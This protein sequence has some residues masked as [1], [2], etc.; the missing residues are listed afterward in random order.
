MA[1]CLAN[2]EKP[3]IR[4]GASPFRSLLQLGEVLPGPRSG[5]TADQVAKREDQWVGNRVDTAGAIFATGDQAA[6]KKQLKVLGHIGLIGIE[7]SDQFGD[8][9]LRTRK[10]LQNAQPEGFPKI[11]KAP[12]DQLQH[13]IREGDFTHGFIISLH[14]HI[15]SWHM[16]MRSPP[17]E[18]GSCSAK[19]RRR[20]EK[21]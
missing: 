2:A 8:G 11:A 16:F 12:G 1:F 14:A 3:A 6:L 15:V 7:V 21:Q 17:P 5:A 19:C 13:A 20:K 18:G 9:L 4:S 10:R